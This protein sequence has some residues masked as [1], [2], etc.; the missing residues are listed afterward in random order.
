MAAA[1]ARHT[2]SSSSSSLLSHEAPPSTRCPSTQLCRPHPLAAPWTQL[3]LSLRRQRLALA[4]R[5]RR[6]VRAQRLLGASHRILAHT[7]VQYRLYRRVNLYS[8]A[9]HVQHRDGLAWIN[10]CPLGRIAGQQDDWRAVNSA[11]GFAAIML[12]TLGARLGFNF[13]VHLVIPMGSYSK[14]ANAGNKKGTL[15]L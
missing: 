8:E 11:L 1:W 15:D 12:N 14:L 6:A 2:Q 3:A 10:G 5:W 7:L 13:P 9:F 4:R